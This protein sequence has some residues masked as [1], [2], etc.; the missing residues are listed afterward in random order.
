MSLRFFMLTAVG[1]ATMMTLSSGSCGSDDKETT[2]IN[3]GGRTDNNE[4]RTDNS[5]N[6]SSSED[7]TP[8]DDGSATARTL[9]VTIDEVDLVYPDGENYPIEDVRCTSSTGPTGDVI[10]SIDDLPV[11]LGELKKLDLPR[12]INDI[13][14]SPYLQPILLVAAINQL[15]NDKRMAQAMLDYILYG[16][17]SENRDAKLYHFPNYDETFTE[18]YKSEWSQAKQYKKVD[19]IRGLL[20]G[21]SYANNYTPDQKPY[22]MTITIKRDSYALEWD[23]IRLQVKNSQKSSPEYIGIWKYDS[24]NDGRF[25][26]F[27]ASSFINMLH[28][29]GEY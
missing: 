14:Q 28:G 27:W 22:T 21:A 19:K 2:P 11:S 8:F 20:D 1:L 29:I 9:T 26:I 6:G 13:H 3:N 16:T 10:V 25:D 5:E 12:S 15:N 18:T 24:D 17:K 7:E 23:H 4:G